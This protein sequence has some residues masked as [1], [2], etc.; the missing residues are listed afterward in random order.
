MQL[1]DCIAFLLTDVV[2]AAGECLFHPGLRIYVR[3][4]LNFLKLELRNFQKEFKSIRSSRRQNVHSA[5]VQKGRTSVVKG[6]ASSTIVFN[7]GRFMFF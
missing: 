6:A 2:Q 7:A 5:I 3:S 1:D 4:I